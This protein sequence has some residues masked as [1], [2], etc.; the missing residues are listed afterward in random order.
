MSEP[1]RCPECDKHI[2]EA[3][4]VMETNVDDKYLGAI[5]YQHAE[6]DGRSRCSI[7]GSDYYRRA[8]QASNT[9]GET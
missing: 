1:T 6:A 7:H 9:P 2:R 8:P 5:Q 3:I 4:A